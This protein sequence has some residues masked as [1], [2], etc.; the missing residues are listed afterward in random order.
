MELT[1]FIHNQC[2]CI[3]TEKINYKAVKLL[4]NGLKDTSSINVKSNS[5]YALS[6]IAASGIECRDIL[7]EYDIME[8]LLKIIGRVTKI[9]ILREIAW[10]LN[11]LT[12]FKPSPKLHFLK[13]IL[14]GLHLFTNSTDEEILIEIC[15]AFGHIAN[16]EDEE[17]SKY[18]KQ[19]KL[20]IESDN[21]SIIFNLLNH[22]K[23]NIRLETL[24][25]I[26]D[27]VS[28]TDK[29]TNIMLNFG[30]IEKLK[31]L[32]FD[33]KKNIKKIAC[34]TLSN[35]TAC[36]IKEIDIVIK[37]NLIII[38]INIIKNETFEVASE[39]VWA[40]SNAI[41]CGSENH[42]KYLVNEGIISTM[43]EFVKGAIDEPK[44]RKIISVVLEGIDGI[45]RTGSKIYETHNDDYD[46]NKFSILVEQCGGVQLLDEIKSKYKNDVFVYHKV[47]QIIKSF[48]SH[49]LLI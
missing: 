3:P 42:I 41:I 24:K 9:D 27:L 6:N 45:L 48:L 39:A 22:S 44:N 46:A 13:L 10:T 43:F 20:L 37:N 17:P 21:L 7:L 25:I 8:H 4:I 18:E 34:R 19:M 47:V 31:C 26:C 38:L 15:Y 11:N 33:D 29:Q 23:Y 5:V 12:R 32:L 1:I 16:P 40:I 49:R 2:I 28:D 14:K 30:L 35:I 36:T